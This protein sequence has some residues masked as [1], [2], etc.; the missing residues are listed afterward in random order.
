MNSYLIAGLGVLAGLGLG[1]GGLLLL[2]CGSTAV[3]G[4]PFN[5]ASP[6]FP[7]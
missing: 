7:R 5:P 1:V 6:T 3:R 2:G 4:K